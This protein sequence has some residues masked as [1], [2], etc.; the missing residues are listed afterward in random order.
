MTKGYGKKYLD[1][2]TDKAGRVDL[3]KVW[4]RECKMNPMY[5]A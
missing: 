2:R 5:L 1:G 3:N 4:S